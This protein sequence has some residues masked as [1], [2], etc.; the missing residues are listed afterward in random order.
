MQNLDA[1]KL[2]ATKVDAFAST[3]EDA[4]RALADE[5]KR[6][7]PSF[8]TWARGLFLQTPAEKAVQLS[9]AAHATAKT[10]GMVA[11]RQ[12]VI[13]SARGKLAATTGIN[14]KHMRQTER[15]SRARVRVEQAQGWEQVAKEAHRRLREAEAA[16]NGASTTELIDAVSTS[17]T[18]SLL[19][20]VDTSDAASSI[21]RAS[22]GVKALVAALPKRTTQLGVN[23]PDDLFDLTID[24][25]MDPSFDLF[26]W[27][28][29]DRLDTAARECGQAAAK[30]QPLLNQLRVLTQKT[31]AR[32]V[33][34]NA[35][36]A[37][38]EAP[39]LEEAMREVPIQ[40]RTLTPPSF[41]S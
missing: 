29:M 15:C 11:A 34:E 16:C 8:L 5:Q 39:F 40:I 18:V 17:K 7:K 38:L 13:D 31:E 6:R 23:E 30:L 1:L 24:L 35:A 25:L 36:L 21:Q 41:E 4:K 10:E 12:W 20:Y 27:S 28:N 9:E 26:S 22:S 37:D 33:E 19:S 32:L 2:W 3:L 14:E